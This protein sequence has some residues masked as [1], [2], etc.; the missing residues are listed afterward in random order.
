MRDETYFAAHLPPR[1]AAGD[2]HSP[3]GM[4]FAVQTVGGGVLA[5]YSLTATVSLTPP[6]GQALAIGIP[7]YYTPAQPQTST[8]TIR[9]VEQFAAYLPPGQARAQLLADASGIAG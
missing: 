7:G 5:F 8:V 9:Y 2:W 4:V 1:S 3:G 6:P